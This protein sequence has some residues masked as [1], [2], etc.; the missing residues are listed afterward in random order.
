[1]ERQRHVSSPIKRFQCGECS[2][3]LAFLSNSMSTGGWG[4][5]TKGAVP[6]PH[7]PL[8]CTS[9]ARPPRIPQAFHRIWR[10]H[11]GPRPPRRPA[12]LPSPSPEGQ[13]T[14]EKKEKEGHPTQKAHCHP[15]WASD[16]GGERRRNALRRRL[17]M[18]CIDRLVGL[19]ASLQDLASGFLSLAGRPMTS[20][21]PWIKDRNLERKARNFRANRQKVNR[22]STTQVSLG[23]SSKAGVPPQKRPY[24]FSASPSN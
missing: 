14:G 24:P 1:M 11:G 10:P 18:A 13:V 15:C 9:F 17:A 7:T 5:C 20:M 2:R 16:G 3:L 22:R 23:K 21:L 12:Q 19:Q 6:C 4:S 8:I